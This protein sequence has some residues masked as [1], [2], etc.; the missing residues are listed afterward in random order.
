MLKQENA[1]NKEVKKIG[2]LWTIKFRF[3]FHRLFCLCNSL[4]ILWVG[5]M[6]ATKAY[7]IT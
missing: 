7:L 6:K 2:G 1:V 4:K 3:F 5:N